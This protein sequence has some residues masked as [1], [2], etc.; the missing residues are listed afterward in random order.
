EISH[1]LPIPF[2]SSPV[3]IGKARC[4]SMSYLFNEREVLYVTQVCTSYGRKWEFTWLW[5]VV[6]NTFIS[7]EYC[8]LDCVIYRTC[9]GIAEVGLPLHSAHNDR[10]YSR[11]FWH[12]TSRYSPAK[13][14]AQAH[15]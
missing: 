4:S 10:H 13:N 11:H 12:G 1:L 5:I 3:I 15:S 2:S 8:A 14:S 9:L 7:A 6:W